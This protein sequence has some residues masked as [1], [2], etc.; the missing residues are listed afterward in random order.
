V[1]RSSR[2]RRAFATSLIVLA[3]IA[4]STAVSCAGSDLPVGEA[5]KLGLPPWKAT[6]KDLFG[7]ELDPAA[8]G[9]LPPSP[10]KKDQALRARSQQAEVVG[11]VRVQT[12]TV[13]TRG[14]QASYHLGLRFA[15][16]LLAPTELEE[17]DFEVSVEAGD[18]SYG[19]VKAQDTGLQGR[20]FVGFI[21]R[22]AGVDDEIEIHFF[23]APDSAEVAAVVQEA[24]ALKEVKTK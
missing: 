11:R 14:G 15:S 20:T 4:L 21:K 13:D 19:L 18:P 2:T 7:D 16:P 9:I 8:L 10:P 23:L 22:F 5:K 6:D 17:R 3:P 12:V 1:T 24:V